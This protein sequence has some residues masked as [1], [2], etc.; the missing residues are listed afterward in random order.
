MKQ[1]KE[2]QLR[3]RIAADKIS[4][5]KIVGLGVH[6]RPAFDPVKIAL[7]NPQ[8]LRNAINAMCAQCVGFP[9]SNWR[10]EIRNCTAHHCALHHV[11]PY[12]VK[13][14]DLME[15]SADLAYA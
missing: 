14:G 10:N 15:V 7:N 3:Q 2:Y 5:L 12:Q 1:S 4:D 13:E 9:E 11:R 6:E 8:S